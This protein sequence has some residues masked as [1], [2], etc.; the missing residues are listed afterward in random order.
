MIQRVAQAAVEVAGEIVGQIDR[1][2]LVLVGVTTDDSE[3]EAIMLAEKTAH[4]RIFSDE[5]GKFN[6]SLLDTDG[7]ALVVSQ[8]TLYADV[9]KGRRPSFI[10]AAPPDIAAPLVDTYA[11]TLRRLG[12]PVQTGIFGAMMHVSL[13]NEGPVTLMIDS[14]TFRQS[15]H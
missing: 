4:L 8:F 14:D 1:G 10:S 15:R 13:V 9:R 3:N 5:T 7:A 2:M 12:V 6:Y 11:T